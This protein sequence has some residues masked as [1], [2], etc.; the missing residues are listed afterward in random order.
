MNFHATRTFF[1][2]QHNGT[3]YSFIHTQYD[4]SNSLV[5]VQMITS[6]LPIEKN[7]LRDCAKW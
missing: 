1:I 4:V 7:D 6:Y 2:C 5:F 3:F